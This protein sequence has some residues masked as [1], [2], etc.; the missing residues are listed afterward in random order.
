MVGHFAPISASNGSHNGSRTPSPRRAREQERRV[1]GG[2]LALPDAAAGLDVQE[3]T[4]E[5]FVAGRIRFGPCGHSRR[6]RRRFSVILAAKSRKR[7]P[8][9]TTPGMVASAM[10]TA[11]MVTGAFG[12][13]LS[14]TNPLSGLLS[15]R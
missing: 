13:V 12:S 15:C 6:Y 8:R 1:D 14:R 10:P 9:S 4:E 3:M 7:T 2:E 11:A 5:A